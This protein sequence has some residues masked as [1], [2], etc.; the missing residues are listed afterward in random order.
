MRTPIHDDII[1]EFLFD[2]YARP[3][4]PA[5]KGNGPLEIEA[6]DIGDGLSPHLL[7]DEGGIIN[8]SELCASELFGCNTFYSI[9]GSSLAIRAMVLL[10]VRN[11]RRE[12]REPLILAPRNVSSAFVSALGFTGAKIE[13]L[14][15]E[16]LGEC[17]LSAKDVKGALKRH[18]EEGRKRGKE[19]PYA[20]YVTSPDKLGNML[21]IRALAELCREN[22]ILLLVDASEGAYLRFLSP[23]LYPTDLGADMCAGSASRTL[24]GLRGTAY[25]HISNDAPWFLHFFARDALSAFAGTAPSYAM[26]SSFDILNKYLDNGYSD[27][28]ADFVEYVANCKQTLTNVGY[29][30]V[31]DEPMKITICTKEYG[32]DGRQFAK[33]LDFRHINVEYADSDYV[34][35]MPSPEER[36]SL[37]YAISKILGIPPNPS[38]RQSLRSCP[39]PRP[40]VPPSRVGIREALLMP[41][42]YSELAAARGRILAS[43]SL[44]SVASF[45]LAMPGEELTEE[46]IDMLEYY[47]VEGLRVLY[48]C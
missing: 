15:G 11:A 30:L 8:E 10:T 35:L 48:D 14:G 40:S 34:V 33:L 26:L 41:S 44:S 22:G 25:L 24:G 21:D 2:D 9:E 37:E 7:Y 16:A 6:P 32:Y 27:K 12:G 45:P 29:K 36:G 47:G 39:A 5:H 13:W 19:A 43:L 3:G 23:S 42:E 18:L 46:L 17:Y 20:L 31:G 38:G 1:N 28:L 4:S